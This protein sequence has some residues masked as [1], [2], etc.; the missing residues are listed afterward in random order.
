MTRKW[1]RADFESATPGPSSPPSAGAE[2][3]PEVSLSFAEGA[4]AASFL[5]VFLAI[6][7]GNVIFAGKS[8]VYTDNYNFLDSRPTAENYGANFV[9]HSR[10]HRN[11]LLLYANFHDPGATWWQWEPSGEFLR[12]GLRHGELPF[13][14]P[15]VGGGTP[16]M[17]NLTPA[18][19]FPPYL[20]MVALGNTAFLKNLYFL[21]LLFGAGFFTYVFLRKHRLDPKASLF[22]ATAFMFCG[23]L[24]QNVGS[25]IGQTAACAPFVLYL[26]RRFLDRPS[27]RRSAAI[28][29]G[30]AA[31]S[32]ASFPPL[33]VAIFGFAL[34]Y[35][36]GVMI[37]SP[38]AAIAGARGRIALRYAAGVAMSIG[39]VAAYY[40]PTFAL[41]KQTPH[42]SAF[43]KA[44]GELAL[45]PECVFQILSPR[46]LGG[47]QV[48]A[49]PPVRDPQ[50]AG[51]LFYTG[52]IPL[53]IAAL[54]GRAARSEKRAESPLFG[55]SIWAAVFVTLKLFGVP[56]VQW[57]G[58]LPGLTN[59]HF[60]QYF[61]ILLDLLV[62][63]LAAIGVDRLLRGEVS[64]Q[65]ALAV[66]L[67]GVAIIAITREV[68]ISRGLLQ[69]P[70][71]EQWIREWKIF[72]FLGGIALLLLLVGSALRRSSRELAQ[73]AA[74]LLLAA[75]L[76]EAIHN[77]SFP[78]Q[79]AWDIWRHPVPYVTKLQRE[80]GNHRVFNAVVFGANAGSAFRVSQMDSLHTFNPPRAYDLYR[81]Y[82]APNASLFLRS[83]E[84]LPPDGVLDRAAVSLLV[85]HAS[86]AGFLD[87]AV[88]RGYEERYRDDTCVILRRQSSPRYFFSSD[89]RV[90]GASQALEQIGSPA[91]DRIVVETPLSFLSAPNRASDPPVRVV[92]F[93]RNRLVLEVNAPRRGLV[94][95][96]ENNFPGWSATVNGRPA[97]I[98][99]ANFAFRAI[100][101]PKGDST[102]VLSYWPPGLTPGLAVSLMSLAAIIVAARRRTVS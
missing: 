40:A 27:W 91:S 97:G 6:A 102:V 43:Y 29:L 90:E 36:I 30:Y 100:E 37:A 15:Y 35:F 87:E 71:A 24:S 33:L 95:C 50:A 21:S 38:P 19:F 70:N 93:H 39:L 28:A 78:R 5:V 13:W 34:A 83:A 26:T 10:W 25:F 11:N 86:Q 12:D 69:H 65:R 88:R 41:L 18:F 79:Y 64:S 98:L 81:R 72:A 84:R 8:L 3:P 77:A 99:A 31:V 20:L 92:E 54:S 101:V 14:D 62:A 45:I 9:P 32:L 51:S 16:A 46:L 76:A 74:V 47:S 1:R 58:R 94:Y 49:N 61:G 57:I 96:S 59:I 63:L 75:L 17:A 68:A 4:A 52:V 73:P 85:L 60:S 56:P 44:A 22:G 23:G 2:A 53:L 67:C 80:A 42:V 82:V 48:F 55:I 89:Y 7:Y 66:G